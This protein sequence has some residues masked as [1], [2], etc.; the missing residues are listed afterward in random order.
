MTVNRV[1]NTWRQKTR[2]SLCGLLQELNLSDVK[3]TWFLHILTA[4]DSDCSGL[5]YSPF[6]SAPWPLSPSFSFL[7]SDVL[8]FSCSLHCCCGCWELHLQ[9][10]LEWEGAAGP[11]VLATE[12]APH[13]TKLPQHL[14]CIKH[15]GRQEKN[16][17]FAFIIR[18]F[19][20][21]DW[22]TWEKKVELCCN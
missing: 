21:W 4:K 19:S 5:K 1:W 6:I 8:V 10:R 15:M 18:G 11:S 12:R 20:W 13:R 14:H 2:S 22:K 9:P 16:Y 7:F 3:S 17:S